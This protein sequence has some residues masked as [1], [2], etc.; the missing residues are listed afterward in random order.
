[1]LAA[2]VTA[3]KLGDAAK[4]IKK[5]KEADLI[6]IRLDYLKSSQYK[7]IQRAIK[8]SKK[9]FIITCRKKNEGGFFEGSEKQRLKIIEKFMDIP[10]DYADI[11]YSSDKESIKNLILNKKKT[12][13][14]ISYHNFRR[15]PDNITSI[16]NEIK[17][18][19]PDLIKIVANANSVADNFKIFDIIKTAKRENKEIISFCMG[20]YGQFSRILSIILGSRITYASVGKG[21]ESAGGQLTTKEMIDYY[22]IK[23]LNNNTQI[24]GLI[25]NPVEH[26]WSHIIHNAAFKK[27]KL[28]AVY[29]K[30]RVDRLEEFIV[31]FKKLS[32][33]GFSVTT[34]HKIAI[35]RYLDEIDKKSEEIGAVNTI[36]ARDGK[37][38]GYNT[39]CD[40]AMQALKAKTKVNGKKIVL[41]GA[42]GSARAVS[43]GL[44]ESG[45]E[46]VIL[47]RNL[48]NARLLAKQFGCDYGSLDDLKK[49][50]YDVL[51]NTTLIGMYP[52][53]GYSPIKKDLILKGSVVFDI[54][55]NP[56]KTKLLQD[57]EKVGCKIING[58][59]MLINGAALQFKLWTNRNAPRDLMEKS[60][61]I[62][63]KDDS[64]Q[65]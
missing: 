59:D 53:T 32:I 5:S 56:F 40:G 44:K 34:P 26:S 13:V 4:E 47:N 2:V 12:K 51:I 9:H 35:M 38:I 60:V 37:L 8:K 62:N 41:L 6:E 36:V 28:N 3:K 23:E 19:K 15:I 16:Y 22:R 21:K 1:M 45:A 30:F 31:Y 42:G 10:A 64:H 61:L 11:E 14:I 17:K 65:N 54:V 27:M 43:Y 58:L 33:G 29:L 24:F 20:S 39:D 50:Y 63:L 49:F 48:E 55:F 18:L 7:N 57:A 52:D 46:I 25:G